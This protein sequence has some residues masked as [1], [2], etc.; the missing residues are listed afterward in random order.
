MAEEE[1]EETHTSPLLRN[2]G[3][4]PRAVVFSVDH[5]SSSVGKLLQCEHSLFKR[6]DS[7]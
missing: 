3:C 4:P 6:N 2:E 5:C 7:S 1:S